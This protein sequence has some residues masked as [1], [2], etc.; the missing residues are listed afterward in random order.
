MLDCLSYTYIDDVNKNGPEMTFMITM[1]DHFLMV[2]DVFFEKK[3]A[4]YVMDS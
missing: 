1:T 3:Q 2:C 4:K